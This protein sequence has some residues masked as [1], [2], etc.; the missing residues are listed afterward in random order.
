MPE[1]AFCG[2]VAN[3][4]APSGGAAELYVVSEGFG[5]PVG[6]DT[7][8]LYES[9]D[10]PPAGPNGRFLLRRV[11][12]PHRYAAACS[13]RVTVITDFVRV[14][15]AVTKTYVSPAEEQED[16]I[17]VM[18]ARTVTVVRVRIEVTS[19][20]GRVTIFTPSAVGKPMTTGAPMV[21]ETA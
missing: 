3:A 9:E 6:T 1:H 15:S 17:D 14:E 10:V 4:A 16:V 19:R 7:P 20:S 18:V 21:V 8:L 5:Q 2:Q 11:S 13:I 12:V